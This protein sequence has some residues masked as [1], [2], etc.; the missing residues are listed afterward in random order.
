MSGV[1]EIFRY[2]KTEPTGIYILCFA[3]LFFI[4]TYN[5]LNKAKWNISDSLNKTKW[6]TS[7]LFNKAHVIGHRVAINNEKQLLLVM[8]GVSEIFRYSKTEPT[9]IYKNKRGFQQTPR[10]IISNQ[11]FILDLFCLYPTTVSNLFFT[12]LYY[13]TLTQNSSDEA[14]RVVVSF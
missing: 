1:S 5:L 13:S 7:S 3:I 2:S 11:L 9:G 6:S 8:Y 14:H 12:S 10:E 4:R